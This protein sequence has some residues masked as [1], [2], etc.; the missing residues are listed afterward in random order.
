MGTRIYADGTQLAGAYVASLAVPHANFSIVGHGLRLAQ[1]LGAHR[2][3]TYSAIPTVEGE[4]RKRA[5]WYVARQCISPR[6]S[7]S[8]RCLIAMDRAMCT[9]LGRP[10]SI[11]DEE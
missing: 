9:V 2:R 10:C 8:F 6:L 7:Y 11:Q 3:M 4:L 1:D 5:F